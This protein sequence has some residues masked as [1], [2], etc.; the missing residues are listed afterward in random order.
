[1]MLSLGVLSPAVSRR[2]KRAGRRIRKKSQEKGGG[3]RAA[4]SGAGLF[5]RQPLYC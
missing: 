5:S 1:M 3:L 2:E 4:V